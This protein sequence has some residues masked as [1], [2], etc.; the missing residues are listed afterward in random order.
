MHGF[1]LATAIALL[2]VAEG[3][4]GSPPPHETQ[5]WRQQ[6]ESFNADQWKQIEELETRLQRVTRDRDLDRERREE[7]EEE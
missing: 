1:G 6:S 7:S 5:D 2:L 4:C 3:C